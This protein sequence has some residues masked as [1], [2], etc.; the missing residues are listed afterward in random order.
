M[1]Q[2]CFEKIDK[3]KSKQARRAAAPEQEKNQKP[4]C[5]TINK[6]NLQS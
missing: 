6:L 2:G 3:P 1:A 4:D 5:S